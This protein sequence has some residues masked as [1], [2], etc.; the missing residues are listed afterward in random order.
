MKL[1]EMSLV[2]KLKQL[3]LLLKK[4]KAFGNIDN[5]I[6]KLEKERVITE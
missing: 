6:N 5:I 1:G 4:W 2:Q 3:K